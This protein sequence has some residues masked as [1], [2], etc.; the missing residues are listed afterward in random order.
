MEK[1]EYKNE[2]F[3]NYLLFKN[4]FCEGCLN[5]YSSQKDHTCLSLEFN[6]LYEKYKNDT[7]ND[8]YDKK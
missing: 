7:S 3:I 8:Q 1:K 5:N 6:N 4:K 2:S